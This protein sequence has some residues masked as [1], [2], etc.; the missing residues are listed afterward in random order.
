VAPEGRLRQIYNEEAFRYLLAIE[1]TRAER[2]CCSFLL[3]LVD[4]KN[5]RG[6]SGRITPAVAAKLLSGLS[7]SVR[8]GDFI[9]WFR[10]GRVAGAVLT[11][12][13]DPPAPDVPRQLGQRITA[14]L[15]ERL[16]APLTGRVRVLHVRPA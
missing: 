4:L 7:L 3:V 5:Q 1:R 16:P 13:P 6:M 9:G 8:D 2:S 11:Q 10:E 12:G 15:R 14:T